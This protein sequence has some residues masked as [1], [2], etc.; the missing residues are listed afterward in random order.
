MIP[1]LKVES[2]FG[3]ESMDIKQLVSC[4]MTSHNNKYHEDHIIDQFMTWVKHTELDSDAI[5]NIQTLLKVYD[6]KKTF[7]QKLI[8]LFKQKANA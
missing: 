3:N 7:K 6:K 1:Y 4:T 8:A 5:N 2:K